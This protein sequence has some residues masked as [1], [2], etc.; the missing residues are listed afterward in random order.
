MR[1]MNRHAMSRLSAAAKKNGP[2]CVGLDTSPAYIPAR[3]V[4]SFSSPSQAVLAYNRAIVERLGDAA[5][6][7]KIQIAYYEALGL[8]GMNAY[9]QTLRAVKDAGFIA[10][11]DVKRNDI[12]DTASA[13]ARA[14]FSGDFEADIVTLNPYMGFDT[15]LPFLEYA[16]PPNGAKGMFVLLRT[17]NAGADDI[18]TQ[19]LESGARVF[20]RVGSELLR[21]QKEFEQVYDDSLCPPVGAVVGCTEEQSARHIRDLYAGI[22]FLIPG[23]GAQGGSARAASILLENAGG[24]VNS[25]RAILTAWQKDPRLAPNDSSLTIDQIA[26]AAV[27]ASRAAKNDLLN[28][29]R[30]CA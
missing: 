10:I 19:R 9:A 30:G 18:E 7:C 1:F 8:D 16:R 27:A 23:Y 24:V 26:D 4:Q 13:Y 21:L 25:S 15:L 11:A 22:F 3:L 20:D 12:A 14:H 17:S 2:L 29:A 28:V 6:C 5:C